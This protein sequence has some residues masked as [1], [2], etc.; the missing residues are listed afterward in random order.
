[1]GASWSLKL[2]IKKV[3]KFNILY[4]IARGIKLKEGFSKWSEE[5]LITK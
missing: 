4:D 1:M 5:I 3:I 2:K